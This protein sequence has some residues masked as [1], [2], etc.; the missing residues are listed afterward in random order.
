MKEPISISEKL[1]SEMPLPTLL[2]VDGRIR[3][4]N[5]SINNSN[6]ITGLGLE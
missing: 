2:R 5:N 4:N 6:I 3:N 1:R